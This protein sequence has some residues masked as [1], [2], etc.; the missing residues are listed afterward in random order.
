MTPIRPA[1]ILVLMV[2]LLLGA[3]SP[4]PGA[5]TPL[6]LLNGDFEA[7]FSPILI[8]GVS[9]AVGN[10]WTPFVI[11][12]TLAFQAGQVEPP[13]NHWQVFFADA[14]SY[15]AGIAQTVTGDLQPQDNLRATARVYPPSRVDGI[16]K[17]IGL[18]PLGG[19]DPTAPS[20]VWSSDGSDGAWATLTVTATAAATQT[21]VFVKVEQAAGGPHGLVFVDDVTLQRV[22]RP[23]R[24]FLPYMTMPLGDPTWQ[25]QAVGIITG[26]ASCT[27][28][29]LQGRVVA[30]GG[31]P[32]A[33]VRI[34]VR[35][36]QPGGPQ[37]TVVTAADGRWQ[38]LLDQAA[39][40]AG[41]WQVAVVDGRERLLSPLVGQIGFLDSLSAVEAP[42]IPTSA[43][44]VNGHQWLTVNFQ[45]QTNFPDYTLVSTRYISCQDNHMNHNL[46]VWVI[47][48]DGTQ[49]RGTLVRFHERGG[50]EQ[51]MAT[52]ADTF[53]PAGYI[54]YNLPRTQ[55][56]ALHVLGGASDATA[57]LS[58]MTPP[59]IESCTGN[60]WG[61]YSYEVIF[62]H[63]AG[64]NAER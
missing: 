53:K 62:Q 5:D 41:R 40:L 13:L 64:V 54:D 29:G 35:S 49:R 33:G 48:A 18:D 21:T 1:L 28:T 56:F 15:R 60:T 9:G 24:V 2:E 63:R 51:D 37:M 61:H 19:S 47:E 11:S 6:P 32:Q 10:G 23:Q 36:A 45:T 4:R 7:G 14:G 46:R 25:Y 52:G 34:K 16:T 50:F 27:S 8:G 59:I 43:D 12:G 22:A 30:P 39:P 38:A 58:S 17:T 20:V 44:C 31:A 57:F 26:A 42:G 3:A 55:E